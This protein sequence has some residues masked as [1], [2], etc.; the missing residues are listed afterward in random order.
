[1]ACLWLGDNGRIRHIDA[2][3]RNFGRMGWMASMNCY[4]LGWWEGRV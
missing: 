2:I 3:I 1:M 4:I